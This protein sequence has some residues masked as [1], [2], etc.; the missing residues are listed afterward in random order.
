MKNTIKIKVAGLV[1][2]VMVSCSGT[3]KDSW[4]IDEFSSTQKFSI[5]IPDNKKVSNANIYFTGNFDGK[6]Y[7][8]ITEKDTLFVFSEEELP[9]ENIF[10][11]FYGGTFDLYLFP[12]SARG[13]LNIEVIIPFH[14]SL[15]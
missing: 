7:G 8:G 1:L 5:D 9:S 10:V 14:K 12:S 6:I 4:N 11:D 3:I 13:D 15:H 2:F